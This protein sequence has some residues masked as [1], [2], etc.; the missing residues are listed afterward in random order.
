MFTG[1]TKPFEIKKIRNELL[2]VPIKQI[3]DEMVDFEI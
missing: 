3:K 1:F 2:S